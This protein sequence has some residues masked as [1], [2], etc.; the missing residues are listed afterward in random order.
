M[1]PDWRIEKAIV[2]TALEDIE[3]LAYDALRDGKRGEESQGVVVAA[4]DEPALS[5]AVGERSG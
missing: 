3:A 4:D 1:K 2:E 5:A